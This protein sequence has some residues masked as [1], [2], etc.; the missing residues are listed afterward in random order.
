MSVTVNFKDRLNGAIKE[1]GISAAKLSR[2]TG[3][4]EAT[5]SRYRAGKTLPLAEQLYFSQ[6]RRVFVG[7][8]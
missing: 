8:Q 5:I 1:L 3:L 2:M 6:N 4:T 7:K